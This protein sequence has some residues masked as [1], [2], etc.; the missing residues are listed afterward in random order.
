MITM[1]YEQLFAVL[2]K[3]FDSS[4]LPI[5]FHYVVTLSPIALCAI[6][7]WLFCDIWMRYVR[8]KNFLSLKYTVLELRLPKDTWKS[9]LAM[10]TVL[11]SIHNTADGSEYARF[12]KGETRPW[13]SLEII[14]IEGQV[15]FMVWT[16]DRRKNNLM[17]ALY[18]QY[19]GIEITERADYTQA[20]QFD[21]SKI[22]V[23]AAEFKF[24]KPDPYPIKTYVDYGLDKDPKEEFKVDPLTHLIEWLGS[25]RP[26]EQAWFQFIVR[27]HVAEQHKA[28]TLWAKTDAWKDQAQKEV[29]TILKRDPKTKV[30]GDINPDTG[31][32]KLPT[33][34]KGEQNIVEAIE[35]S[36]TKLP[37]DVCVRT[38][39]IAK[40]D[41]FDTPF[42]IGGCISSM[43]QFNS[44]SLNGFKPNGKRWHNKFAGV[45]WED[46]MNMRRDFYGRLALKAYRRRSAFYPPY[47]SPTLVLNTEE[48]ATIWHLPGSVSA[49]PGLARVPS[50]KAEAPVNLPV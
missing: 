33:I 8:I 25:L 37:F 10:E 20:V 6:L 19:P 48:L 12:W 3:G 44:E 40:K 2:H 50:K 13:Y 30:A 16:E 32:A 28:G 1:T 9:P 24:T 4:L 47:K 23:W 7:A 39:Y 5:I 18:S 42:G 38:L 15:K 43:K 29:N 36:I 49:T 34:S 31:Y 41:I 27:A 35:R 45:P 11:H 22:R 46:F 21:P 17:S 26:N 14:S